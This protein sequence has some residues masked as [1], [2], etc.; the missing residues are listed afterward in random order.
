[1]YCRWKINYLGICQAQS[2]AQ[3]TPG[4][5]MEYS[6]GFGPVGGFQIPGNRPTGT[7][8]RIPRDGSSLSDYF[9]QQ[10]YLSPYCESST[11]FCAAI[12]AQQIHHIR[13]PRTNA[14]SVAFRD[15]SVSFTFS[16]LSMISIVSVRWLVCLPAIFIIFLIVASC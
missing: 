11:N 12:Q 7:G 16:C 1:M 3:F 2:I 5:G 9:F 14:G 6:G 8:T 4:Y 10:N 13:L 15:R